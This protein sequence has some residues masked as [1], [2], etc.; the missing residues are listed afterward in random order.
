MV[1]KIIEG[2]LVDRVHRVT[3]GLNADEQG[4]FS[5]GRECVD[6]VFTLKKV[7]EKV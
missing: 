5:K 4:C 6:Q 1:V 7:G 3:G 2:I